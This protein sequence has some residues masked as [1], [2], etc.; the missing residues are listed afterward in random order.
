ML[1]R[2]ILTIILGGVVA[3]VLIGCRTEYIVESE[4]EQCERLETSLHKFAKSSK[5]GAEII[6]R[7]VKKGE[8]L[9]ARD[10]YGSTV[11]HRAIATNEENIENIIFDAPKAE[12]KK[13]IDAN[14]LNGNVST[15]GRRKPKD[16]IEPSK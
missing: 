4:F 12:N 8:D 5:H 7:G 2:L 10:C 1:K 13:E 16:I 6:R 9:E 14:L 15:N 11:L 3:L